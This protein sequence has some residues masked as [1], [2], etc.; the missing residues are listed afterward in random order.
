MFLTTEIFCFVFSQ[1][2]SGYVLED[3]FSFPYQ[4]KYL[5]LGYVNNAVVDTHSLSILNPAII[6]RVFY[7][8][9]NFLYTPLVSGG[10]FAFFNFTSDIRTQNLYIPIS[11][12]V[13][14]ITSSEAEKINMFK[15]SYGYNFK[16]TLI[17]T[18]FSLSYYLRNYDINLGT[19]L[20]TF[21]QSIDDYFASSAN[22]DFGILTPTKKDYTWGISFLN[23]LPTKF[24]D[25]K[26]CPIIRTSL[27][28]T[29][30]T[31]F[32]SEV[33][34]YTE[35][36]IV[37]FYEI[38][39]TS[40]RWGIGSTY[41]FF[42][43]PL[44]LSFSLSYYKVSFGFDIEKDNLN[45]SYS[46]GY[47][48]IGFQHS[49]AIRYQFNFYPQ[50]VKKLAEEELQKIYQ[51]K[52]DLVQEYTEQKNELQKLKKEQEKQQ[53]IT[54]KLLYAKSLIEEKNYSKAKDVIQEVLKLDPENFQ[55]K[56]ML[57]LVNKYLD[58]S[59]ISY[60]YAL[61][62]DAYEKGNYDLAIERLNKILEIDNTNKKAIVLL[63]FCNT[64]K[65]ILEKKY[66]DAK[67]ELFEI[68]KLEPDNSSA[69]DLLK[70]VDTLIEIG[71]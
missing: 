59:T 29:V 6:H 38:N 50:E 48:L 31:I 7:K 51:Y 70:K 71:E 27:N 22:F 1:Q 2:E 9:I 67:T 23:I 65:L 4:T 20:K 5:G 52:K 30:G 24:G 34:L 39:K 16:E 46:L 3:I 58:K 21:F 43:I 19:N 69:L 55:A 60:L 28:H 35:F 66:N 47:N 18:N 15:E 68:L 17:Y 11:L 61:A 14:S 64:Q 49:F 42:Y 63:K 56:E 25:E 41:D 45:F 36:D 40:F 37:D 62:I 26:L 44:S 10:N 54:T 33:K 57:Y 32:F 8:E 53:Y 12:S 13:G